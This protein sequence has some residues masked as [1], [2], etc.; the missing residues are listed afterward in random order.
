MGVPERMCAPTHMLVPKHM[1]L[2][3]HAL[4]DS[5]C[6]TRAACVL[7]IIARAIP[8][9]QVCRRLDYQYFMVVLG[10]IAY[11][12]MIIITISDYRYFMVVLSKIAYKCMII[13]TI[14]TT[15]TTTT[16]RFDYQH[17]MVALRK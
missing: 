2:S 16:R 7:Q 12:C 9:Q 17:F 13:I 15:A 3:T 6:Y 10:K 14:P 1:S 4:N 5:Q 11:K 8:E